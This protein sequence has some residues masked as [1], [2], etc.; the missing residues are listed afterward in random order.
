MT[1]MKEEDA[2]K[3][4]SMVRLGSG[5]L[6]PQIFQVIILFCRI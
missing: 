5:V 3:V 2:V 6:C 4:Y 1:F